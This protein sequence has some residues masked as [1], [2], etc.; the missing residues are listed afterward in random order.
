MK[1]CYYL[2]AGQG[3]LEPFFHTLIKAARTNY[4]LKGS[5]LL[6][7]FDSLLVS[8]SRDGRYWFYCEFDANLNHGVRACFKGGETQS[9]LNVL[10]N[11]AN[12]EL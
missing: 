1:K 6:L 11:L 4:G 8:T 5:K 9:L 10:G 12:G 7:H 2:A 3:F